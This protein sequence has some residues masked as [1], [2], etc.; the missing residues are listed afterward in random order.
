MQQRVMKDL[1]EAIGYADALELVRGWG[2]RT[3]AVPVKVT[4]AHPL[5]LRLGLVAAE[6]L[7]KAFGGVR[8]QLPAERDALL[9]ERNAAIAREVDSGRSRTAVAHEFGL[10]RQAIDKVLD[11]VREAQAPAVAGGNCGRAAEE[12]TPP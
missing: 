10:S 3:L 1:V 2:G 12:F 9:A 4:P 7:V 5:A 8:L 11:K 6:R